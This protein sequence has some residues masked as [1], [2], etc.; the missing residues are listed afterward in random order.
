MC[1]SDVTTIKVPRALRDRVSKAASQRGVSAASLVDEL[2]NRYEREQRL[3][4][5]GNA[6]KTVEAETCVG[7][8]EAW[9][10]SLSDGLDE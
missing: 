3:T 9:D 1:M 6:Y 5:V 8:M 2:L 7:E 10:E 4:A